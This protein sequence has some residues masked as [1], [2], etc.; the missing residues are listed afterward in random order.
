MLVKLQRPPPDMRIF[1]PGL[2]E[3]SMSNTSRPR[4]A[5]VRAHIS[6]AAPAPMITTSGDGFGAMRAESPGSRAPRRRSTVLGAYRRYVG[7]LTERRRTPAR[8][9]VLHSFDVFMAGR[10]P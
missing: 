7:R 3:R 10:A 8:H 2:L 6:P 1:L 9:P 5:A 4:S